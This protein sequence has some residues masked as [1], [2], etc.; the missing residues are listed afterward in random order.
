MKK[1]KHSIQNRFTSRR[2]FLMSSGAAFL[3]LPPL[4]S[5]MPRE[6]AAQVVGQKKVRTVIYVGGFGID[7]YQLVPI[8]DP[9]GL[10]THPGAVFTRYK[11]LNTF[12]GPFSRM[13]DS[14]FTSMYPHM[15]I[16]KGLSM[17]GGNYQGHNQ[18]ILAGVH[19]SAVDMRSPDHG[20]S[21]DLILEHS[22]NVYKPNE[23]IKQKAIRMGTHPHHQFSYD[24]SS[25]NL[26]RPGFL[27]GDQQVFNQ[28]FLGLTGTPV[29]VPIQQ[30]TN[31]KLV[32][33][34]V[35][36]DLKALENN[37]RLSGEDKL[38]LSRYIAGV[39]DVQRKVQAANAGSGPTC[40]QPSLPIDATSNCGGFSFPAEPVC[41]I[42]S[43][44]VM[45]DNYLEMIR[46]A[47][48]CDLT[49]VVLIQNEI[50]SDLPVNPDHDNKLHHNAEN[51]DATADRQQWGLK[52]MLKL[53]QALQSTQDPQSGT[54][55]DNSTIF[56][57][58]ELGA[59]TTDHNTFSMPAVMFG[60]G[61]GLFKTGYYVDY[62]QTNL[63]N[64]RSV[65]YTP[66][67]PYKQLLQSIMQSMGVPKSEYMQYG[68]GKGFGDFNEGINQFGKIQ[69]D[70]FSPYRN[71]HNDLLPFI[72]S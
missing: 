20:K 3:A 68:D 67:R 26:T 19:S 69:S 47:F 36:A 40:G 17:C 41:Q 59:W 24:S 31:S 4:L 71:E 62:S 43:A 27:Q 10:T 65:G 44:S 51:S 9:P 33:D 37:P 38:T 8:A 32:V 54:L 64:W 16:F 46:L 70:V 49:R 15:N 21:I 45:F 39:F 13:I 30:Q 48:L 35:Y 63:N 7:P 42:Q 12:S 56:F 29:T 57:T 58:N 2:Q 66:G 53:A 50:W 5:L 52:K 34:Q 60:R 25:G 72:A 6:V 22:P 1:T 14:T 11:A 23:V 61:G 28:L 55:L 18:S